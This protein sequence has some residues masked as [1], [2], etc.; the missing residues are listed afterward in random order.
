[1]KIL[2]IKTINFKQWRDVE[3]DMTSLKLASIVGQYNDDKARSNAAGKSTI[4]DIIKYALFEWTPKDLKV[5]DL[6]SWGQ[7]RCVV[8]MDFEF[9]GAVY[10]VRRSRKDKQI[11]EFDL[12]ID[13]KPV[14]KNITERRKILKDA[15]GMDAEV[16]DA[17]WFFLQKEANKLTSADPAE[18]KEY[19]A[20]ILQSMKWQPVH[21]VAKQRLYECEQQYN[22]A[23][24]S[25]IKL[26]QLSEYIAK[27][28]SDLA[29]TRMTI[30][31]DNG[32]IERIRKQIDENEKKISDIKTSCAALSA[33]K[34]R[35]TLELSS[36]ND[37]CTSISARISKIEKEIADYANNKIEIDRRIQTN[38]TMIEQIRGTWFA[39]G[40]PDDFNAAANEIVS[41][42]KFEISNRELRKKELEK[43]LRNAMAGVCPTCNQKIDKTIAES[44]QSELASISGELDNLKNTLTTAISSQQLAQKHS[45]DIGVLSTQIDQL[46]SKAEAGMA[47]TESL[48]ET[49]RQLKVDLSASSSDHGTVSSKL[50]SV[51]KQWNDSNAETAQ[52]QCAGFESEQKRLKYELEGL[53]KAVNVSHMRLGIVQGNIDAA[54]QQEA[55]CNQAVSLVPQL[56]SKIRMMKVLVQ[57]FGRDGLALSKT[58][59]ASKLIEH[60]ANELL[61]EILPD[62]HVAV[63]VD[64]T[65][66]RG[67]LNFHISTPNGVKAYSSFS[68]GE[69]TI[70]DVCLRM[71]LSKVLADGVG[72]KY[73]TLFLDEVFAELDVR[74]R[75]FMLAL[76]KKLSKTFN[77]IFVISHDREMQLAFPQIV[78]VERNGNYSS[79]KILENSYATE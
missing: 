63:A 21:D 19:L 17:T 33:E 58:A 74:N 14:G 16:A 60:Y 46:I 49:L 12:W 15:L 31:L 77:T 42:A 20:T 68:G 35:L 64:T 67:S 66:V 44:L 50:I 69:K 62:F 32:K 38:K 43:Q 45:M 71:A 3:L 72:K 37:R 65:S 6:I 61:A 57:M 79:V 41:K 8:E 39:A 34:D 22:A 54:R 2:R 47:V 56:E 26:S 24:E 1:M 7:D 4:G 23:Y 18:R 55:T 53:S 10:Q 73:S 52:Q 70:V 51:Q 27:A 25:K 11:T 59:A 48:N 75:E 78:L 40:Y 76:L 5:D 36:I 28:E 30:E 9:E 29:Q 13:G